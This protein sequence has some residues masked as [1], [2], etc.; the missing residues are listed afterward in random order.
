MYKSKRG[1]YYSVKENVITVH[2]HVKS[3]LNIG[4]RVPINDTNVVL[5]RYCKVHTNNPLHEYNCPD[6]PGN[7]LA[8]MLLSFTN[9]NSS[10]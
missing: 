7:K 5:C 6:N 3:T 8:E 4:S 9:P 10:K 2:F 1:T